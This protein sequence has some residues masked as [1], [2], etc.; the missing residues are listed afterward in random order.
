MRQ[1]KYLAYGGI[2]VV[3]LGA[4]YALIHLIRLAYTL[5]FL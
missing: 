3:Y 5:F 2:T 1:Y 4:L